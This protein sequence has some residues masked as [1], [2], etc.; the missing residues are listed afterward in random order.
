MAT[1]R[2][3]EK[4]LAALAAPTDAPQAYNWD[5]ELR[6]FGVVV[7]RSGQRTFVVRGRTNGEQ[8]K[9]KIG[10][11]NAPRASDGHAWTV[12]LARI[13]A[14]KLLGQMAEGK[15]P[16]SPSAPRV[17]GPTL[18]R[19]LELHVAN[20][21]KRGC[22]DRSI[23]T[24]ASEVPRL[25][26][27]R[28]DRPM[29]ELTGA[30]N[31]YVPNRERV[32]DLVP[33]WALVQTLSP[34][35]RDLQTF[36]LFTGMRSEAARNTRWADV[37]EERGALVVPKPKG[38]ERKAFTL[39]LPR[40]LIDM[41]AKRRAGNLDEFG[42]Y[43]GDGGWIFPSISRDGERVQPLA[44]PKE[45]RTDPATKKKVAILPG[46]HTLRRTYLS[47]AAEA[48]IGEIDR[49]VLANHAFGRQDV[50][51]TYIAQAFPH[52]AECQAKIEA[53]LWSR[54]TPTTPPAAA[55]PSK[56]PAAARRGKRESVV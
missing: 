3:T 41:L 44:E 40:T 43:G 50:N 6:G 8:R 23:D 7:G 42:P 36:C 18:R 16:V 38:G 14:R 27:D 20:M 25:L 47:V 52:L 51:S 2:L 48:G 34:V 19:G 5:T 46:L 56:R 32:D 33:W 22:S 15:A 31:R 30:R 9:I 17:T 49:H 26:G 13:E 29:A 4:T 45:Y 24:I 28:M 21:R 10:I 35:R 55:A 54:L 39:P 12:L 37:D 1:I 11:A 53:A